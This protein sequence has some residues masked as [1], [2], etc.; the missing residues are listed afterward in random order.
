MKNNHSCIICN[1]NK[2]KLISNE[3][4]DSK[5]HKVIQC[6]SCAHIQL[7]PLP[8]E[9]EYNKFYQNNSQMRNVG[10]T[11]KIEKLK[12]LSIPDTIRRVKLIPKDVK[13]ADV[14]DIGAGYGFFVEE[15]IL[16]GFNAKGVELSKIKVD[17]LNKKL[18]KQAIINTKFPKRINLP[19]QDIVTLFFMLEHVKNPITFC[20]KIKPLLSKKGLV[21]IEVPNANTLNHVLKKAGYSKIKIIHSQR[22]NLDNFSNWMLKNKPQ[23]ENPSFNLDGKSSFLNELYQKA[24][25]KFGKSDTLIALARVN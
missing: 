19:K 4:R 7:T 12:A 14:L 20:K 3:V 6:I 9:K 8:S 24:S 13:K 17:Y 5:N 23:I 10:Q 16:Q 1:N 11:D 25:I 15:L 2:F 22:Y 21:I 18:K